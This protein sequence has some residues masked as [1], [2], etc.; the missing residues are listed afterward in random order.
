MSYEQAKK[1]VIA[2]TMQT[3]KVCLLPKLKA[4]FQDLYV[5]QQTHLSWLAVLKMA[6]NNQGKS[7]N[8]KSGMNINKTFITIEQI[9]SI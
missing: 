1:S 9:V 8:G 4:F 6:V 3:W 5:F 2:E 7:K